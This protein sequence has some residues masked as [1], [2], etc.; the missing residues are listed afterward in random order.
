MSGLIAAALSGVALYGD[1][2]RLERTP[3]VLSPTISGG[4]A[5]YGG[6]SRCSSQPP[7]RQFSA[8][9]CSMSARV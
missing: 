3:G 9:F 5:I 6:S 2:V 8:N 1:A 4:Q 7:W